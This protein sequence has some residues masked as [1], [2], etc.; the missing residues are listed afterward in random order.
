MLN[1]EL[2]NV[3]GPGGAAAVQSAAS[4]TVS[5]GVEVIDASTVTRKH[6]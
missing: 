1:L 4:R 6:L 5:E 3:S 2:R